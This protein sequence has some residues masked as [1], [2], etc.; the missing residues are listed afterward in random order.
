[1]FVQARR[2]TLRLVAAPREKEPD[3]E[4]SYTLEDGW[5]Y[6]VVTTTFSNRG[7]RP[8]DVELLDA[9][10][11][12]RTFESSPEKPA[13]LF[14]A[15]D[16]AFGQAYGVVA[17][18][19]KILGVN[20][21]QLLLRY[22][23]QNGKVAVSLEAG[24]SHRL[25]RRI[26]PGANL[27]DLQRVAE[28][29]SGKADHLI[30]L[31]VN[32][33]SGRPVAETDV[34][35]ARDGKPHA[36]GRT[37][38]KGSIWINAGE[39]PGTLSVSAPG[40]GSKAVALAPDAPS[41]LSV[42]LLAAGTVVAAITD[43]EGGTIPCK[44]QFIGRDGTESP[45]FGPDSGEHAVKNVYYSHDGRFRRELPP[46]A[47]DVII[48]YGPEY[49]AVFTR[50]DVTRGKETPLAAKMVR[51]VKTVGWLSADFHSHSSPSGDNTSSQKG[52]VL[53]LLCEHIE[54]APC[55]E[56][57]RLSTYDPHLKLLGAEKRMATCVGIELTGQPLPLNHQNAF[58]M[59]MR[60]NTQDGGGPI[61]D[62]DPEVQ[63]ERLALWDGA[64][65]KLVQV[66]HPDM[67]WMFGD[68]NGDTKRDSGFAGMHGHI[69]VIEVHPPDQIF[70]KLTVEHGGKAYNNT[71]VNWLQLLNQGRRIPGVVNT[72]AHY[73]FHG[74]GFLRN[75]LKCPTDNPADVRTLDIVHAAERGHVVMSSG[76]FMEVKLHTGGAA[77]DASPGD[78]LLAPG[79]HA[80]LRIRVQCP[81]WF[82]VD[83][84][85]VFLNGRPAESFNF[86]RQSTPERFSD[87]TMK[88]DQEFPIQLERDT[89]VIVAAIGERSKLGPVMGPDHANDR[90][91]AVSN[92]IFVD[93][94][95][96]GFKASNDAMGVLPVKISQ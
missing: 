18:G 19:H 65:D 62:Q 59:I 48:S 61:S 33:T 9:I 2:V 29:L 55:T 56:H 66:N 5:P 34:V 58:P 24:G 31:V 60:P 38:Q 27:F 64:S 63:I 20:A 95:G 86:T 36:W 57:N 92:P 43:Q 11:A 54:F 6:L 15:Y 13:D 46:G 70:G 94:D 73:N 23:D 44:V 96:G 16:K 4:V 28:H 25:V 41:S 30:H 78:D 89:H 51:S 42:E 77:Q 53:N 75:Y 26:I 35:L 49:D 90:P 91:V 72:D 69:D 80:S 45:D 17:D 21:R 71:I 76:P 47:Y 10:R 39:T 37:D 14:W 74:S 7:T 87:A 79:G 1:V 52:R 83:R 3:I 50:V 32:D 68:R 67:G 88:F 40:H 81:N 12:D 85:Q 93:I 22:H 8:V 84:V 82:D